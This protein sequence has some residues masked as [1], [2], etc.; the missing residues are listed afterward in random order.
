MDKI[1]T[2]HRIVHDVSI[3]AKSTVW[4]EW[5]KSCKRNHLVILKPCTSCGINHTPQPR[6]EKVHDNCNASYMCD[7]CEAYQDHYAI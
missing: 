4:K 6:S 3:Y 7:G 1:T 5:C 2:Q